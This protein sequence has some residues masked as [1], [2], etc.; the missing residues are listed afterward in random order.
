MDR[1]MKVL[2]ELTSI[3]VAAEPELAIVK[4]SVYRVIE[5]C[6]EGVRDLDIREW[7][8]IRFW[9]QSHEKDKP[10][11]KPFQKYYTNSTTYTDIWVQLILFY[12]RSFQQG[13][14]GAEYLKEQRECL[15]Q[16]QDVM[17][18]QTGE[19]EDINSAVFDLSVSLIKH[20][21]FQ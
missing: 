21:D 14:T 12:W 16:L 15:I 8:E 10:N 19:E 5:L 4:A 9:L 3:E 2:Y 6:L 13:G 1:N 11:T 20:S 17:Y 7:N 18:L